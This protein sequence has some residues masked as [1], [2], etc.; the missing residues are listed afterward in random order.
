MCSLPLNAMIFVLPV[1]NLK[2]CG[3]QI[4]FDVIYI[5]PSGGVLLCW[6]LLRDHQQ[7]KYLQRVEYSDVFRRNSLTYFAIV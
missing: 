7:T 2:L 5:V 6:Q 3:L 1:D 4:I